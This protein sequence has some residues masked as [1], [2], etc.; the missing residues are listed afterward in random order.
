MIHNHGKN[1]IILSNGDVLNTQTVI[2][3]AI[4]FRIGHQYM[5]IMVVNTVENSKLV[6]RRFKDII[7]VDVHPI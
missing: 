3:D 4:R 1:G 7:N 5:A 6:N 2:N